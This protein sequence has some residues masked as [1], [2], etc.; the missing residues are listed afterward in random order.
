[1]SLAHI[2]SHVRDMVTSADVLVLK[3]EGTDLPRRTCQLPR[4]AKNGFGSAPDHLADP[5]LAYKFSILKTS[6]FAMRKISA[7]SAKTSRP[8]MR[9]RCHLASKS[10]ILSF[11]RSSFSRLL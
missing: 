7:A 3:A 8:A 1:M 10:A 6:A 4:T 5:T 9:T 2:D 11:P